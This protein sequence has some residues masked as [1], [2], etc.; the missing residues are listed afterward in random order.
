MLTGVSAVVGVMC[1]QGLGSQLMF[2]EDL[3]MPAATAGGEALFA[4]Q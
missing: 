2:L 1:L 4:F 3:V